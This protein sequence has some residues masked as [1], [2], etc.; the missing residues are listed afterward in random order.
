MYTIPFT[1]NRIC[2]EFFDTLR[3]VVV[4]FRQLPN[5]CFHITFISVDS[6]RVFAFSSLDRHAVHIVEGLNGSGVDG[7]G[8][9][10]YGE[11]LQ[12]FFGLDKHSGF[13]LSLHQETISYEPSI[14]HH[15][16]QSFYSDVGVPCS[17]SI[18][19][20]FSSLTTSSG[21]GSHDRL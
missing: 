15:S 19:L 2:K 11:P 10:A 1:Q 9:M 16:S 8:A 6:L 4:S 17:C 12:S 3:G 13:S 14:H 18:P 20:F 21:S 5:R 7:A